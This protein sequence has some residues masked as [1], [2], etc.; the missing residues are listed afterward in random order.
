MSTIIIAFII[1]FQQ[2]I[3]KHPFFGH[4]PIA[5]EVKP[6]FIRDTTQIA[7]NRLIV[8]NLPDNLDWRDYDGIN[9]MSVTKNQHIPQYCGSC[10]V[11]SSTSALAARINIA[12]NNAF[13]SISLSAQL[14]LDCDHNNNYGCNG[15]DALGVYSFIHSKGIVEDSCNPY[16]AD[17][18][19]THPSKRICTEEYSYCSYSNS[20]TDMNTN[21]YKYLQYPLF[22]VDEY[23]YT[24]NGENAMI[25]LLQEGPIVCAMAVNDDF[26]NNY[27]GGIYWDKTGYNTIDHEIVIIGY[28]LDIENDIKYWIAMN[29]WGTNWGEKGYFKIIRGIN[30]LAIEQ[31]CVWATIDLQSLNLLNNNNYHSN[32]IQYATSNNEDIISLGGG[33]LGM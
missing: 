27:N 15:G 9:Y 6:S 29:S 31:Y 17:S 20:P 23:G 3:S 7:E 12:R 16:V 22:Y 11:F 32:S 13:P 33:L 30:N 14:I 19:F 5:S 25:K 10:W 18:Y 28:G 1:L 24:N 2:V 21:Q 8:D 4:V 26:Y